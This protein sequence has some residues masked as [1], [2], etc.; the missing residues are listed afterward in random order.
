MPPINATASKVSH[1]D[2]AARRSL[3]RDTVSQS[4]RAS[5][6]RAFARVSR[7]TRVLALAGGLLA[8]ALL[9]WSVVKDVPHSWSVMR[10][11]HERFAGYTRLQRDQSYGALLPLPMDI[12]A[13]YRQY[14]RPGDRYFIQ[15]EN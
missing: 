8:A 1:D 5:L 13:W 10:S 4:P 15:I 12:F 2:R 7:V 6:A 3:G 9:A 14:L 11:E